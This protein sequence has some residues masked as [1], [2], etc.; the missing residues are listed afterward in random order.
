M[1]RQQPKSG[2]SKSGDYHIHRS[3]ETITH[4]MSQTEITT[5][6]RA[7]SSPIVLCKE[8]GLLSVWPASRQNRPVTWAINKSSTPPVTFCCKHVQLPVLKSILYLIH[9]FPS[10]KNSYINLINFHMLKNVCK[11]HGE[12]TEI[13]SIFYFYAIFNAL[14]KVCA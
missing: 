13:P 7:K 8:C 2:Y 6:K 9:I 14:I 1:Y 10:I 5:G 4:N 3:F 12:I 11:T